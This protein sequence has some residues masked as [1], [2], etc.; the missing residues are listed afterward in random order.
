MG[1]KNSKKFSNDNFECKS[2][3]SFWFVDHLWAFQ[4]ELQ[5]M[6]TLEWPFEQTIEMNQKLFEPLSRDCQTKS[7]YGVINRPPF[8]LSEKF[9]GLQI[10]FSWSKKLLYLNQQTIR[11]WN[12]KFR[13][14]SLEPKIEIS[15]FSQAKLTLNVQVPN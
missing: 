8:W 6:K 4:S 3:I 1:S 7:F 12:A 11:L 13:V 9:W 2:L 5:V 14:L 10:N 15:K